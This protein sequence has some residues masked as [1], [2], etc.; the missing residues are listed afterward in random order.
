MSLLR[1]PRI[2]LD[3]FSF[4]ASRSGGPGGQNVNKVATRVTVTFNVRESPSLTSEQREQ[5]ESR[6][7][8]RISKEGSLQTVSQTYRSQ[9][10]NRIDA[11]ER[12]QALIDSAFVTRQRRRKTRPTRASVKK[13][14][15]AKSRRSLAK[16]LR[17]RPQE[18]P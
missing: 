5:I 7:A 8:R 13:R 15:E 3:E 12:M 18:E 2:P 14:L 1:T 9:A 4:S 10:K 17:S 11:M 6:L 16:K